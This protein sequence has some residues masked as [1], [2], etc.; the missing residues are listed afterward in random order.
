MAQ[1]QSPEDIIQ[2]LQSI[3]L[4][5]KQKA[6]GLSQ[7]DELGKSW[8]AIGF[9]ISSFHFVIPL[10]DSREVFPMPDQVT[11]VPKAKPWIYGIVNLRGELLP[12]LDLK[13]YLLDIPTKV[14]KKSRVLVINDKDINSGLLVDEVFGLKHFQ[15]E[16]DAIDQHAHKEL[17][18]YLTGSVFQQEQHWDVFS[19][20][21]LISD[22]RFINAAA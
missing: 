11:A 19:F 12:V 3:E 22:Q 2:I 1:P 7:F 10:D 5:S 14:S 20:D 17:L 15:R 13:H 18:P 9:R 6:A 4:R 16:P 8:T 21:K